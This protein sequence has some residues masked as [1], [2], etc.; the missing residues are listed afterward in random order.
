MRSL[1][2]KIM[3]SIIIL[4]AFSEISFGQEDF[5]AGKMQSQFAESIKNSLSGVVEAKWTSPV[6]LWVQTSNVSKNQ[7]RDIAADVVAKARTDLKQSICVHV[8]NGDWE[9]ISNLC[10]SSP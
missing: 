1:S 8:H 9:P 10:W 5:S 7:A 4:A 6:D 2:L 3:I